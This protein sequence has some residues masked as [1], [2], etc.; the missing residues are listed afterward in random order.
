MKARSTRTKAL[1][2][3]IPVMVVLVRTVF[4]HA[5]VLRLLV[6]QLGEHGVQRGELQTRHLLIQR[7]GQDVH[8][9]GVVIG[10]GKDL[11]LREHL[12]GEGR[13]HHVRRMPGRAAEVDKAPV[14]KQQN[15]LPVREDHMVYLRLDVLAF[16]VL[17]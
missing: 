5:D 17:E 16:A 11:D 14:S 3:L 2:T 8:A 13:A 1:V 12:V 15:A 4:G 9:D 6:R 7:L 10:V